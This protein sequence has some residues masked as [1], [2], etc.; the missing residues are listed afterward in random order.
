LAGRQ[1]SEKLR[2]LFGLSVEA[3]VPDAPSSSAQVDRPGVP[4]AAGLLSFLWPGL[5]QAYL[6]RRNEALLFAIPAI[7]VTAWLLL[8]LS[9]G[10]LVFIGN[11]FADSIFALTF[12]LF[13]IFI[14]V[15][16]ALAMTRAYVQAAPRRRPRLIDLGVMG[17]LLLVI[18]L[19]HT[20]VA[21]TAWGAYMVD[22]R[23][24]QNDFLSEIPT[25][26]PD[27]NEEYVASPT[28]TRVPWAPGSTI[29]PYQPTSSPTPVPPKS[30]RVTILLTGIDRLET[31]S[32]ALMDSL[33]VVSLDTKTRH[34]DMVSVP[35]DT[36]NYEF[37]WGGNAGVNTKINNFYNLVRANLIHA[38]DPPL[39]ALKKE[40]GWLVGVKIDYYAL[41]DL[42]G[43]RVLV[44]MIGGICVYNPRAINDPFTGTFVAKGN[45][46][47]DGITTLKYVRSRHGAGDNDYTRANRQ[48]DVLFAIGK[49]LATPEGLLLLPDLLDLASTSVQTDFPLKT[50]NKYIPIAQRLASKDLSKCVL[51]PPYNYHPPTT[52]TKGTWTSRLRPP[53][54]AG[55]SVYLFGTDSRY[56]GMDG[57]IPEACKRVTSYSPTGD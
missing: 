14:G 18:L 13:T 39:T 2:A 47:M 53:L 29:A 33:L 4:L 37:Y 36:A 46:C 26:T 21:R 17:G 54:V 57:I 22:T 49:K 7:A 6:R 19:S 16:R 5:G 8:Q 40:I 9:Q 24:G 3:K 48:Q 45:V 51:G 43:F 1:A 11:F 20:W 56:Y 35:R 23:I 50:I 41:V 10:G 31:N 38:P 42:H 52:E 15:W 27:P 32:H 30:N 12:L 25:I 34:V 28:P 44:D 55:L